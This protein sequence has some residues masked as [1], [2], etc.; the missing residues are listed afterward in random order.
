MQQS[1]IPK[2]SFGILPAGGESRRMGTPKLRLI[3]Q[4]LPLLLHAVRAMR[5]GGVRHLCVV[6]HPDLADMAPGCQSQGAIPLVLAQPTAD[7]K[8]SI[9]AG[10]NLLT[11]QFSPQANDPLLLAPSDLPQL[12][13]C[14]T[15]ALLDQ[16]A[17]LSKTL[18][19]EQACP[20][21]IPT[22]AEK[23]G[24]PILLPWHVTSQ[25]AQLG[26]EEGVRDLLDRYP[27]LTIPCDSLEADREASFADIDTPSDYQRLLQQAPG[28]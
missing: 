21:L 17:I 13:T 6:L 5:A 19:A 20:I 3:W 27:T 2:R 15:Q 16:H 12:S 14:L 8:Q 7:M 9:L 26:P 1:P 24:H 22:L 18:P 4:G 28:K 10:V 25:I 11:S 23:K